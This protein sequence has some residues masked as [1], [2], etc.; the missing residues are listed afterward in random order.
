[1]KKLI[2][3]TALALTLTAT[4]ALAGPVQPVIPVG[5]GQTVNVQVTPGLVW[6]GWHGTRHGSEGRNINVPACPGGDE[7]LIL[8]NVGP[9]NELV[10]IYLEPDS[11]RAQVKPVTNTAIE[12]SAGCGEGVP[13]P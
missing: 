6:Y 10:K 9:Q 5:P 11:L 12:A 1:M 3:L 2:A 4:P 13:I 7:I 8:T